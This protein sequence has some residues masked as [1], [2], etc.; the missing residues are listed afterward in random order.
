MTTPN[1]LLGLDLTC[2]RC[3]AAPQQRCTSATGR[4]LR[5]THDSRMRAALAADPRRAW[6]SKRREWVTG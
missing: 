4:I 1:S 6:L 2:P 5:V 3:S